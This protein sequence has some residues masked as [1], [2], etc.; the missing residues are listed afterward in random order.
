MNVPFV[1]TKSPHSFA[2]VRGGVDTLVMGR[3]ENEENRVEHD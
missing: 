2:L 1:K 3:V